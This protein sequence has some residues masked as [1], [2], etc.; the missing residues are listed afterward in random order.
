MRAGAITM[1]GN[2]VNAIE[3]IFD[4]TA[5]YS[6]VK[7]RYLTDAFKTMVSD[8]E[9][10]VKYVMDSSVYMRGRMSAEILAANGRMEQALR[11][12]KLKKIDRWLI[13]QA[14]F[15]Q[16]SVDNFCGPLT[17]IASYNQ[18]TESGL[19]H[20]DAVLQ[21]DS[22][23]R[24]VFGANAAEDISNFE[25]GTPMKRLF[26]QFT[27]YFVQRANLIAG[28]YSKIQRSD[29]ANKKAAA[30]ILLLQVFLL[31]AL[32]GAALR[33]F[34]AGSDDDET[35]SSWLLDVFGWGTFNYGLSMGGHAG[36]IANVALDWY[37]GKSF[38]SGRVFYP[39]AFSMIENAFKFRKWEDSNGDF[40]VSKFVQDMA[41][42]ER[43]VPGLPIIPARPFATAKYIYDVVTDEIE[44][45][46]VY[47]FVRGVVTGR[48]SADS[49]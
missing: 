30:A 3:Q 45:T 23:V 38:S 6:K 2:V 1:F 22:V 17:W 48:A 15:M 19:S 42:I 32:I 16:M 39:P 14:Y 18:A 7:S 40:D 34:A 31:P 44:P 37:R 29:I 25:S 21:A 27:G 28:E 33:K 12:G 20:S 8:K 4:M 10:T 41:E 11:P 47:D 9:G 26:T 24:Q 5:A 35:F 36:Q 13:D 46:G 43:I 49:K